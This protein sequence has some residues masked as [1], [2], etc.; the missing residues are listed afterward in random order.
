MS[1]P[2]SDDVLLQH[3]AECIARIERNTGGSRERFMASELVQDAVL[4][5]LQ[6]LAE[7]TSRLGERVKA[8]EPT[9][10]WP[11]IQAFRN[12]LTHGYLTVNLDIVRE[13][14]RRNLPELDATVRR[15]RSFE[16]P[17]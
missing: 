9:V 5:N 3:V 17:G 7:S 1:R 2:D 13:V 6:V 12:R 11:E 8:T 4:R 16:H 14:V 15:M 10:P